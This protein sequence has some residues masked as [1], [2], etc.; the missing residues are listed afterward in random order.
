MIQEEEEEL[1]GVAGR[2]K[3]NQKEGGELT[4][5]MCHK[6]EPTV[7]VGPRNKTRE[8]KPE[9]G[10]GRRSQVEESEEEEARKRNQ[11]EDRVTKSRLS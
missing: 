6:Q 3:N 8:E 9:G 4:R 1:E 2:R 5:K 10:E 11:D 7:R